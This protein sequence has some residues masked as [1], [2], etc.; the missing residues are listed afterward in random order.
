MLW[1]MLTHITCS[2]VQMMIGLCGAELVRP[3]SVGASQGFLGWVAYLGELGP[4]HKQTPLP[5]TV[6]GCHPRRSSQYPP[7]IHAF[8][9]H[10]CR[11]CQ[12]RHPPVHH[13]KGLWVEHLFHDAACRMWC[14]SAAPCTHGQCQELY[15]GAGGEEGRCISEGRVRER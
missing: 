8:S 4:F 1:L 5:A 14:G 13:R 3:D 6:T 11:R 10:P 9:H 2:P 12:C 7:V 15:P